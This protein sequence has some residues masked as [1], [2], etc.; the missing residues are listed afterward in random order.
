M[1]HRYTTLEEALAAVDGGAVPKGSRIVVSWGW[2]DALSD[3]ERNTYQSRC[4]TRGV[5]LSADHRI[6]RHFVEVSGPETLP[7]SSEHGV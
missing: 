3:A 6:S 2:W 7:L 5:T 4:D 1:T